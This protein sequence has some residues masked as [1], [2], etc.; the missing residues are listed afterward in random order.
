MWKYEL[1]WQKDP[2]AFEKEFVKNI[3]GDHIYLTDA[4]GNEITSYNSEMFIE[5][6]DRTGV[7]REV[8]GNKFKKDVILSGNNNDE[9]HTPWE[10]HTEFT[11]CE[12]VEPQVFA[13]YD[14]DSTGEQSP[15]II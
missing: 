10:V 13:A 1:P 12:F 6:G 9:E 2:A 11:V 14:L 7:S 4:I 5:N 3:N 8:F 15:I